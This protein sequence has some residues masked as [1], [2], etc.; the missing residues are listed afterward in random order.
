MG[1]DVDGGM[2][3]GC[4]G[5]DFAVCDDCPK[6]YF[7]GVDFS[8][9]STGELLD[10]LGLELYADHYDADYDDGYIGFPVVNVPILCEEFNDW[11][12]N[13]KIKAAKFEEITGVGAELCWLSKGLVG[14]IKEVV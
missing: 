6:E 8:C 1:I 4:H 5:S 2:L 12:E 7:E 14:L 9:L 3:V 11:I 10:I 13:V